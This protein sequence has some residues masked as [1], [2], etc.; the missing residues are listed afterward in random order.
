[1]PVNPGHLK[2]LMVAKLLTSY[3]LLVK[4]TDHKLEV[5]SGTVLCNRT[6]SGTK[7]SNKYLNHSRKSFLLYILARKAQSATIFGMASNSYRSGTLK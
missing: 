3:E 7:C 4:A 6:Y 1:M 2:K 5:Q